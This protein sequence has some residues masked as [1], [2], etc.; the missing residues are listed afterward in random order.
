MKLEQTMEEGLNVLNKMLLDFFKFDAAK[1]LESNDRQEDLKHLAD[2]LEN[3]N[4]TQVIDVAQPD[5]ISM[6]VFLSVVARIHGLL[7][8][9]EF[10]HMKAMFDTPVELTKEDL[11]AIARAAAKHRGY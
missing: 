3:P 10:Y 5:M 1:R 11:I 4:T 7:S 8:K 2:H 9:E 6:V